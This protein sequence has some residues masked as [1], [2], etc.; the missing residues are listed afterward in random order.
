M[1]ARRAIAIG[2]FGRR[3]LDQQIAAIFATAGGAEYDPLDPAAR[4]QDST[5][6]TLTTVAGQAVGLALDKRLGLALGSERVV[7]GGF[8]SGTSWSFGDGSVSISGGSLRFVETPNGISATGAGATTAPTTGMGFWCELNITSLTAGQ[9]RILY[10]GAVV[11]TFASA[12][13]KRVFFHSSS[14]SNTPVVQAIGATT[15][16]MDNLSI[17]QLIGSH[18]TQPTGPARPLFQTSPARFVFDG[19]DDAHVT[20]FPAAL[21]S[22]CT[23]VRSVPGVGASILTG[24]TIGTT[25]TN[26][27]THSGLLIFDRPLTVA[28]TA[29]VT[30]WANLRAGV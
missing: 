29:V 6:T 25:Y 11:A 23:I 27:V 2:L 14:A 4:Y 9:V 13:Q 19:V 7:N 16:V 24:Q 1:Y 17:R 12:G 30:R 3:L 22:N 15:G 10:A 8:D 18:A 20:T 26:T 5:G 28:E 21:G